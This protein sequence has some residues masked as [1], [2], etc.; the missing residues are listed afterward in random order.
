MC[1]YECMYACVYIYVYKYIYT[2]K[3]FKPL[4]TILQTSDT[5]TNMHTAAHTF[6]PWIAILETSD[7][8]KYV[9]KAH[10]NSKG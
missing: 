1:M 10:V 9:C 2:H 4:I 5:Y 7:T 3:A 8:R 6:K